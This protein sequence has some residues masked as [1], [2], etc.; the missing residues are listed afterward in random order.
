MTDEDPEYGV[1][2]R[3]TSKE[4]RDSDAVLLMEAR[5]KRMKNTTRDQIVRAKL[6]QIKLKKEPNL[7]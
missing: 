1:D 5:L 6:M 2:S 4:E 3:Y 7:K